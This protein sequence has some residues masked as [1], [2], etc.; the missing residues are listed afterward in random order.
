M[1]PMRPAAEPA[2]WTISAAAL[3]VEVVEAPVAEPEGDPVGDP[4]VEP[5]LEPVTKPVVL[6]ELSVTGETVAWAAPPVEK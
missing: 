2:T 1:K 3:E 5:V 4:V 6:P